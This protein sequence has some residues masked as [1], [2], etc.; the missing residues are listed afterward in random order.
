MKRGGKGGRSAS[1][2]RSAPARGSR[3]PPASRP[4]PL[5][6]AELALWALFLLTPLLV[7]SSAQES[8]RLP[9]LMAAEWLGLASLLALC[10]RLRA[11]ATVCWADLVRAPALRAAAPLVL[12]ALAGGVGVFGGVRHPLHLHQ[13]L[14]DLAIGAACLMGWSLGIESERLLRLLGGL[15]WP[16]AILALFAILQFH[17]VYRPLQFLGLA[18]DSRMA[19]TSLAGNPGDL[20]A[21][22]VLPCLIAQWRLPRRQTTRGARRWAA[23]LALVLVVYALAATQTFSALAAAALGT[24]VLWGMRLPLRRRVAAVA[25][26]GAAAGVVL[27]LVLALPPLRARIAA[28]GIEVRAG[29]WNAVLSGRLDGW[30]T[31]AFL[32][33]EH[34]LA[35]VGQG[36]FR[37]EF[38]PAK[39]ALLD[40]GVAFY[41]DQPN[42]SFA[43]VHNELLEVGA[44]LGW[45]GLAALAWGIGM[46]WIALRRL[47]RLQPGDGA[48]P[49]APAALAWAGTAALAV[50]SL[51]QFPFRI[52]LV[53][54]PAL[55]FL[56]WIFRAAGEA[57][58]PDEG[59]EGAP[60]VRGGIS[61]RALAWGLAALLALALAGQTVRAMQRIAASQLL[62]RA[63]ALSLAMASAGRAPAALLAANLAML[64]RAAQLDPVE[65]EVPVARGGQFLLAGRPEAALAP[66]AR[67]LALE[68]HP[69]IYL[70]LARAY[71]A[72]GE[73]EKARAN[74]DLALRLSPWLRPQ[75]PPGLAA[76]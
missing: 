15:L 71:A 47:R 51:A 27:L 24:A 48:E 19:V 65:V 12:V 57:P 2:R 20:A 8:F 22:L 58:E 23:A 54:F 44:D 26:A 16:A 35:G 1:R 76:P 39:L 3:Q 32:L 74:L 68:P 66:Y 52:A 11:V 59:E 56:A 46:L 25:A 30:R 31:A 9:K 75:A 73:P 18:A 63:E 61:G 38:A 10:F 62:A 70:D 21:Y 5:R 72:L 50:L 69:E 43:N 55:L 45:P 36:A 14:A 17:G 7:L 64:D 42:A 28:K 53:A 60:G 4:L 33:A 41:P 29:D 34:P 37:A 49:R 40:R 13:A 67:A 6:W